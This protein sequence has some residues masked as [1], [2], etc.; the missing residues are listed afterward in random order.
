MADE[1]IDVVDEC[2]NIIGKELKSICHK[3]GLW[4]RAASI[5]VF[6]KEGRLLIQKRAPNK[7]LLPNCLCSSASGHLEKGD[8]YEQGAKRELKEELGIGC[9]LKSIGKFS[10]QVTYLDGRKDREHCEIF[11]CNYDGKFDLQKEEV[12]SVEFLSIDKIKEM[13]AANKDQFT[14]G[15]RIEFQHYL[16]FISTHPTSPIKSS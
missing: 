13:I 3:K 11:I 15:F 12:S 16:D 4:H 9:D 6:N 10:M 7:E 5:F 14:P 8:S 1:I 2:N